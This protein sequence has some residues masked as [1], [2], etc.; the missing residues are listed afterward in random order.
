MVLT[1]EYPI[2]FWPLPLCHA[3]EREGP[4]VKLVTPTKLFKNDLYLQECQIFRL[5]L[6][7]LFLFYMYLTEQL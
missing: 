2:H 6:L 1:V 3:I 5:G 7:V 4:E